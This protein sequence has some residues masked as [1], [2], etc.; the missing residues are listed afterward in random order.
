MTSPGRIADPD[1]MFSAAA[2]SPVT[3]ARTPSAPS[4]DITAI[5]AAPPA[6]SVFISFIPSLGFRDS[7]PLSN[8]IPLPTRTTCA[9]APSGA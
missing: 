2:I 3:R 5:T 4:A 6:M 7:P 1:G 8:V 9:A